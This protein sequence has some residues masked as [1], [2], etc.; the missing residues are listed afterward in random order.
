MPKSSPKKH[1]FTLA[2]NKKSTNILHKA[3]VA[4][5]DVDPKCGNAKAQ[6]PSCRAWRGPGNNSSSAPT[7]QL[8]TAKRHVFWCKVAGQSVKV[9]FSGDL[10]KYI[11]TMGNGETK[12]HGRDHDKH[13]EH[14]VVVPGLCPFHVITKV[15][16]DGT[17]YY[18]G[19]QSHMHE[20]KT[21][22][23][24]IELLMSSYSKIFDMAMV[25]WL[26][27]M[28]VILRLP[29]LR[30][31]SLYIY[32]DIVYRNRYPD[33]YA[34]IEAKRPVLLTLDFKPCIAFFLNPV[35]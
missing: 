10:I 34:N 28:D 7:Q 5:K 15:L 24:G 3:P 14:E 16:S 21:S 1:Y 8:L 19:M 29:E 12:E 25:T 11:I 35:C 32:I 17:T 13:G 31:V 9:A 22:S 18:G 4:K 6:G 23:P 27:P 33:S 26:M 2:G 20:M 30:P